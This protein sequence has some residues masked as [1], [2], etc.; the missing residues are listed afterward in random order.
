VHTPRHHL[1]EF[2][3]ADLPRGQGII[4]DFDKES[5]SNE[6]KTPRRPSQ[7]DVAT[8]YKDFIFVISP[9]K[10]AVGNS[11]YLLGTAAMSLD[12]DIL[13]V[14]KYKGSINFALIHRGMD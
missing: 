13:P 14:Q 7:I 1:H 8:C 12:I 2:F 9:E 10:R 5:T 3:K 6:Y 4:H 11:V